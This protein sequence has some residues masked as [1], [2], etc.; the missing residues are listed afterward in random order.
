MKP[1]ITDKQIALLDKLKRK[2]QVIAERLRI[3]EQEV[4]VLRE[5]LAD[6]SFAYNAA[7]KN[8]E[9]NNSNIN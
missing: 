6:A 5:K 9:Q 1:Q 7:K 2:E 4:R 3:K 8:F